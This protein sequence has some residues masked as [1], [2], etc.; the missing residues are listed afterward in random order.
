[1][2]HVSAT[3]RKAKDGRAAT[4]IEGS[5]LDSNPTRKPKPAALRTILC[6]RCAGAEQALAFNSLAP[7]AEVLDILK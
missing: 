1:M 7:N 5:S 2:R 4:G 6:F 3:I